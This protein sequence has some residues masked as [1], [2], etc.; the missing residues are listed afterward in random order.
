MASLPTVFIRFV[1]LIW[2]FYREQ[3]EEAVG[4]RMEHLTRNPEKN[5]Q[6][7]STLSLTHYIPYGKS[8]N[9]PETHVFLISK[10]K[11]EYS[12][13]FPE[14]L[15]GF[16]EL[17]NIKLFGFTLVSAFT[18]IYKKILLSTSQ[19]HRPSIKGTTFQFVFIKIG[20]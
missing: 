10:M 1:F 19:H 16:N 9:L 14:L 12:T 3:H 11:Y 18:Q 17:A 15:L 4:K 5:V 2:N 13:H 6:R 7:S 8:L 20:S